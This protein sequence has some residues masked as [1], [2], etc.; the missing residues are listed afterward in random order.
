MVNELASCEIYNPIY[1]GTLGYDTEHIYTSLL[2]LNELSCDE[3]FEDRYDPTEYSDVRNSG[4][5]NPY[6]RN[7]LAINPH[8]IHIV[9][10]IQYC[11]YTLCIIKT[12]WLKIIQRRWKKWYHNRL[13][14]R[15]NPI[16]IMNRAVFGKWIYS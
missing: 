1:H 16:N 10:R 11:D 15:R 4:D 14:K 9:E 13:S 2:Y 5:G 6:I 8:H 12:H 7:T 3:F